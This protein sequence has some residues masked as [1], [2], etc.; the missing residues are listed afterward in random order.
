MVLNMIRMRTPSFTAPACT[1]ATSVT[2]WIWQRS[3]SSEKSPSL[4]CSGALRSLFRCAPHHACSLAHNT[5]NVLRMHCRWLRAGVQWAGLALIRCAHC[6]CS[7]TVN[8]EHRKCAWV[9]TEKT[10]RCPPRWSKV[11]AKALSILQYNLERACL[12]GVRVSQ[13]ALHSS[14]AGHHFKTSDLTIRLQSSSSSDLLPQSHAHA[15]RS[16]CTV[17]LA[18]RSLRTRMHP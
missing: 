10:L 13:L 17:A 15:L 7:R 11:S 12:S 2:A 3:T 1:E 8:I 5:G 6:D 18:D 14:F 16:P 9:F 4:L